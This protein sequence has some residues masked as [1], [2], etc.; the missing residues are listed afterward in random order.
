MN[1]PK[2]WGQG[3]D[4]YG[5]RVA[6]S[7]GSAFI[8]N[9]IAYGT[10]AMFREDNRYFE[11]HKSGVKARLGA[12]LI[13]PYVA[14]NSAGQTR[15]SASSFLGGAGQAAI[16]LAWSPSSWQGWGNIAINYSIWY[17]T[18]AGINFAREFYPSLVRFYR[19]RV[20]TSPAPKTPATSVPK[21]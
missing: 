19:N 21:S 2:E 1:S 20:L 11:S 10:S 6:S 5:V 16:P 18:V 17:G 15:F 13:S 4:A 14:R 8:G 3:W 7:Y 12:V 9:T